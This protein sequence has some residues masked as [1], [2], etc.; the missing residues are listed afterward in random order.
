MHA[1]CL[2]IA[3]V[4]IGADEPQTSPARPAPTEEALKGWLESMVW[5]HAYSVSE[6]EA[7]TGRPTDAIVA[8]L[9]RHRIRPGARPERSPG[10]PAT[11]PPLPGRASSA[12][13][14][15]RRRVRPQRETKISVFAPWDDDSYVVVD[16]PEAIWSNLGLTYLAHTHVPTIWSKQNVELEPIEWQPA[17]DGIPGWSERSQRHPLRHEIVRADAV[18]MEMWLTNGTTEPLSDLR[19]QNCV[20]LK[21]AGGF[22]DQTNDNKVFRAPYP[23]AVTLTASDGSSPPGSPAARLG[24]RPLPLPALRSP[25]PRLRRRP[26]RSPARLALV[27]RRNRHRGRARPHRGHRLACPGSLDAGHPGRCS[28]TA[29]RDRPAHGGFGDLFSVKNAGGASGRRRHGDGGLGVLSPVGVVVEIRRQGRGLD[30]GPL[31][32]RAVLMEERRL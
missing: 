28:S 9:Q 6:I 27:L 13:R 3:L 22:D 23:R 5:Y 24:Q 4:L 19:V 10:L 8:A 14:V 25:V 26:D 1:A 18:R 12:N 2:A 32:E 31:R 21:G 15:P 20:M 29:A 7:A 17:P 16:I 30:A 11:R